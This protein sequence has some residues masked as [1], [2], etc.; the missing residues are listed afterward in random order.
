MS[1]SPDQ[2]QSLYTN[3]EKRQVACIHTKEQPAEKIMCKFTR[4][5][6]RNTIDL[7]LLM[8]GINEYKTYLTTEVR[9]AGAKPGHKREN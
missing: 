9:R 1:R 8:T 7:Y 2:S 6:G 4:T 3:G 5:A